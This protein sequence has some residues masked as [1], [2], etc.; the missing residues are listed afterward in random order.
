MQW[1][2]P[3]LIKAR[4]SRST[5]RTVERLETRD[6]PAAAALSLTAGLSPVSDR[7][8]N[9]VV[10]RPVVLLIGQ[11]TPGAIVSAEVDG[12]AVGHATRA[13]RLGQY[14]LIERLPVGRTAF[15]VD[16]HDRDGNTASAAV[17]VT[18]SDVLISWNT[19]MLGAVQVAASSPPQVARN[20]AITQ[21]AVLD[22]VDAITNKQ[23]VAG[24]GLTPP[25]GASAAAAVAG[26][27]YEVG[28]S[29][30]P[31]Q[32]ATFR[33]A[34]TE[35]MSSLPGGRSRARGYQFGRAVADA[36]LAIR[37]NDGSSLAIAPPS[38]TGPGA[39]VP[40]PPA[41]A[42]YLSPG[43]AFVTPFAMTSPDQFLPPPP[44]SLDS[45]EYAAELQQVES[46]GGVDS[47]TRTAD[48]TAYA[49][50]WSDLPSATFTPP[51][52]WNQIAQDASLQGHLNLQTEARLFGELDIALADAGISAWNTK[53]A[54][55][56]WR[57]VT[58][59]R[60]ADTDGNDA[61]T[62]DPNWTPLWTTPAFPAYTSAHS[63][64]SGA[65]AT[66]LDSFFG[67]SFA[68]TD[69]GAPTLANLPPRQFTSFQQAADE[70]GF[71]R[72]V[73]GIHFQSD[74]LAGLAEGRAIGA[75]V[76]QTMPK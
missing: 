41:Y 61:T 1:N 19:T 48:E 9:H 32:A 67:T 30:Y 54:Y 73:G 15:Q 31:E 52:H 16:A 11:T 53:Y 3:K 14:R 75:Y 72:I 43:Y 26:A 24:L 33:A 25:R 8:G 63:T 70:A 66:V 6:L 55:D 62:A 36:I 10:L 28:M 58:A 49:R 18:R 22:A 35:T 2:R 20:L 4:R 34:L 7:D 74:N 57:P 37:A 39:W 42:A 21:L 17:L 71:S 47:T 29:L 46:L 65:A 59:I 44:P 56:R 23:A 64:F 51:G 45:P 40:T 60:E 38:D 12:H 50:F 68:F 69:R 5:T 27:A 76:V 13:N